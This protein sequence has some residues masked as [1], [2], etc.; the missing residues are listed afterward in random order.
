M[1]SASAAT[2]SGLCVGSVAHDWSRSQPSASAG[3]AAASRESSAGALI[4]DWNSVESSGAAIRRK[5]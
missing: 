3:S 5:S 1:V 4:G 2:K